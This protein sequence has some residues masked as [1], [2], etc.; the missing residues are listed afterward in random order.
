MLPTAQRQALADLLL[1]V[2]TQRAVVLAHTGD[3]ATARTEINSL[4]KCGRQGVQPRLHTTRL[5]SPLPYA[6]AIYAGVT[7]RVTPVWSGPRR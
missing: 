2:R 6:R 1:T 5:N 4:L 3:F 7:G